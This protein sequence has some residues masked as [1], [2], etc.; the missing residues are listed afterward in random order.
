MGTNCA[1]LLAALFLYPYESDFLDNMIR[2]GRGH[3]KLARS[4]NLCFPYIDD[5]IVFNSK[6]FWEYVKDIYTS[7]LNVEKI[8]QSD[9]LTSY[10]DLTFTIEKDGK[11]STKLY[12]KRDGFDFYIVNFPFLSSNIPSGPSYSVYISQLIRYARRCSY[13]DDF[14]YKMLVERLVSQGYRYERLRN[15]FKKVLWQIS[16]S[17][18]KTSE[19][20]L[21]HS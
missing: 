8:N 9:N 17:H 3:R 5:L 13:Y 7:Q 12:D 20:S 21:R 15:S 11:L 6:K 19:V 2:S 4:F 14:S 1:L 16:R 10:H 18:C